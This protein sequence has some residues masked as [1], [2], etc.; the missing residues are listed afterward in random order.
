MGKAYWKPP[1]NDK[2]KAEFNPGLSLA[3]F[4]FVFSLAK[5]KTAFV[6]GQMN[7]KT[8]LKASRNL[9]Q[10]FLLAALLALP[11][12]VQA[13]FNYTTNN[14]KI[15]ITQY[16]GSAS[17][18]TIPDT[19]NGFPVT[20][21]GQDAFFQSPGLTNV[22][23]STNVTT[24]A[25]NAFFQCFTLASVTI[26]ASVTNIGLGPFYDCQSLTVI[27]VSPSNSFYTNVNQLLFNKSQTYLIQFPGGIGGSYTLPAAVTNV[28]HAFVGNTLTNIS[29]NAANTIYTNVNGVLFNKNQTQLISYPGRATGDVAGTYTVPASVTLIVS[30]AF[31]YVT[32]VTNVIIGSGVTNIGYVAFF[33]CASLTMISVNAAN[34]F[35]SSTNGALFDKN[36]TRL[37][38]FPVAIGGSYTIPGTVTNIEDGAFGDDVALA[39]VVIPNSVTNIGLQAFYGCF[40]LSG[41]TIGNHVRSI[42]QTAFFLCTNLTSL[43]FPASVTRIDAQAFSNCNGLSSVCFEGNQPVD[44]GNIFFFDNALTTI[45]YVSGSTG[46]GASYDSFTTAVCT[47]CG[48]SLPQLFIVQSGANVILAWSTDFSAFTLQSTTNLLLPASWGTV[49]PAPSV[50]GVLEIVTNAISGTKKFYRLTQ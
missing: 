49:S 16:T 15:T 31:E 43:V 8:I 46:W 5:H 22:I 39:H 26:P 27:S 34:S 38:Q 3:T 18:V 42:G 50:V 36:K 25:D 40:N 32:S 19:I 33:D 4:S 10:I 45:L 13:Q 41:V 48:N 1:R 21:I 29:V 20:S 24:L 7:P 44:G 14:S 17:V 11:T 30:A 28:G 35:Y 37:I 47:T 9:I 2:A 23:L 12:V 6:K